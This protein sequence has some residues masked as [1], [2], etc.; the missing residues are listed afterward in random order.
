MEVNNFNKLAMDKSIKTE[1]QLETKINEFDSSIAINNVVLYKD[2]DNKL[3]TKCKSNPKIE[4]SREENSDYHNLTH[5]KKISSIIPV[6]GENGFKF[7]TTNGTPESHCKKC[8]EFIKNFTDQLV[9]VAAADYTLQ[10]ENARKIMK[11]WIINDYLIYCNHV[12]SKN[13]LSVK[14]KHKIIALKNDSYQI[15]NYH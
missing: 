1:S 6:I 13:N 3:K 9:A 10:I 7:T 8:L 4:Y 12:R 5:H 14:D 11:D 15:F 2:K